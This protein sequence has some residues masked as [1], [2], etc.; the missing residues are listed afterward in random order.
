M[1]RTV[2]PPARRMLHVLAAVAA[3]CA[4]DVRRRRPRADQRA[5]SDRAGHLGGTK[6]PWKACWSA[7]S[8]SVRP[9]PSRSSRTAA[10]Q[11]AFPPAKLRPGR[12]ALRISAVGYDLDSPQYADVAAG[13]ATT[14][15]LKLRKTEDLASQ[16]D[17]H[18]MAD[19]HARHGRSE[20][21]A[22]RMHEL[23]HPRARGALDVHR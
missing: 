3:L 20:A 23:P 9:S 1:I 4:A 6:A 2:N 5:A 21:A 8:S 15:D 12:Y 11:F 17:Q 7:P 18:G 16:L 19:Q 22:D 10:G 14:V 13:Q